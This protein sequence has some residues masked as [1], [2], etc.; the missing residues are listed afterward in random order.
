MLGTILANYSSYII[1]RD[2]HELMPNICQV[3]FQ[4]NIVLKGNKGIYN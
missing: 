4:E 2:G 1:E 3:L